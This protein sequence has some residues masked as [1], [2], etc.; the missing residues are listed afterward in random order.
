MGRQM[1]KNAKLL[2]F[3]IAII[4]LTVALNLIFGLAAGNIYFDLTTDKRYSLSE[5]TKDFLHKNDNQVSVRLYISK[6]I[7]K[8]NA[9]LGQYADYLRK[10]L[11]QYQQMSHG[12]IDLAVI[13][14]AP[15]ASTQ[16]EAEKAG[17]REFDFA[18]GK[19]Y[20]YLGASFTNSQGKT[21]S[22]AQFWPQRQAIVEDD[23]SRKLAVLTASESPLLG[24]ISPYFNVADEDNPLKYS[25][26]WPFVEQ[27]KNDGYRV[28]SLRETMP[29]IPENVDG[30]LVFYPLKLNQMAIYALDQYLLRGG[31]V[32]VMTDAFAE[33]RFHNAE[34]YISYDSGMQKFLQNAGIGYSENIL[35]G[36]N[37]FSRELVLDGRKIKYPL[38]LTVGSGQMSDH[39]IM[40]GVN[41][42]YL[43]HSGFF[44]Y[45]PQEGLDETVLF[46]TSQDSGVL[47]AEIIAEISYDN[48]LKNY[49][50]HAK[51]YPLALLVEGNFK[52][53][54][55]KPIVTN[56]EVLKQMPPF[57][58]VSIAKGK[59]LVVG[60]SDMLAAK[61]WNGNNQQNQK[62]YD[63]EIISDNF[64]FLRRAVDYLTDSGFLNTGRKDI[65][66]NNKNLS[67]V[68]YQ[69]AVDSY[70]EQKREAVNH[71]LDIRR[72]IVLLKEKIGASALSSIKQS[73]ELEQLQRKEI[74]A[75]QELRRLSFLVKERYEN[76][77]F[78]FAILLTAVLPLLAIL[79]IGSIYWG[80]NLRIKHKA[81]EYIDE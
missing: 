65:A 32:M 76:F 66:Q 21:L 14:V 38:W 28:I 2:V 17:I 9:D 27:L 33:A 64:A 62:V 67:D 12:K 59:L 37:L 36:D 42:L 51:S 47:P 18:D 78:G 77:L 75:E 40:Q 6:D 80:Y 56:F 16:A 5:E 4:I 52:S 29:Y 70:Q 35:A 55:S 54:F 45:T 24:I 79:L 10:L 7:A 41:Q 39:P 19:R 74:A 72:E 11:T 50:A 23:I 60:D 25:K 61:L 44:N 49:Q 15:F 68:F 8:K 58:N 81:G 46:A 31:K 48:L 73:K 22:I 1:N 69:A 26:N 30:V 71:L 43:N 20:I 3:A 13:E 57:L 53:L 63:A 34:E